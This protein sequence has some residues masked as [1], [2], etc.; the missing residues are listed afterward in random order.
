MTFSPL[1]SLGEV[2][3]MSPPLGAPVSSWQHNFKIKELSYL[4]LVDQ[5][6]IVGLFQVTLQV[7]GTT[8]ASVGDHRFEDLGAVDLLPFPLALPQHVR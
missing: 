8:D 4:G 6:A 1:S 7:E 3:F 5:L 2:F